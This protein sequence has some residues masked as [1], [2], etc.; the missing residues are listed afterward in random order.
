MI[1]VT[2]KRREGSAFGP[3]RLLRRMTAGSAEIPGPHHDR[4]RRTVGNKDVAGLTC[5]W[6]RAAEIWAAGF[7]GLVAA[8]VG[9]REGL[10]SLAYRSQKVCAVMEPGGDDVD[11][12]AL[13]LDLAVDDQ[14]A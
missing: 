6:R 3:S 12:L 1:P 8:A 4:L 2:S 9:K 14:Q 7:M 10:A 5:P 11:D 13:A